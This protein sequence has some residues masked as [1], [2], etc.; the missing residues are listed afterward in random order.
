MPSLVACLYVEDPDPRRLR[1]ADVIARIEVNRKSGK[2]FA[3]WIDRIL[4]D[5]EESSEG[6]R[7]PVESG[8]E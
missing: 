5:A 1:R 7:P 4:E 2:S 8:K 6:L 3:Q